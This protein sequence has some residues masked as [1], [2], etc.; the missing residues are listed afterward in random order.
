MKVHSV[1]AFDGLDFLE[2]DAIESV[3]P[4]ARDKASKRPWVQGSAARYAVGDL[5]TTRL[6]YG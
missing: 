3:R 4:S 2:A 1:I 5:P 6:K